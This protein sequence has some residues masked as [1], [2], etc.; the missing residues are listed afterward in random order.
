M[1]PFVFK[2]GKLKVFVD[3]AYQALGMG[4]DDAN[5]L[6]D[7]LVQ[8]EL[9]GHRS[10][11]VMRTFWYAERIQS[12]AITLNMAP[13]FVT[14]T[15]PIAVLDGKDGI[16]QAIARLAM[17]DAIERARK[18]GVG[19]VSVRNSGHFGTAMYF[20]RM[21][22]AAGCI[23]ILTT[24]ASPAMAPWGG[25]EKRIGN[26]PWSI[27][28]PTGGDCPMVLDIA[29][30]VVARGKIYHARERG[31][32]IPDGWAI[33]IDGVPT[34]DPA[35]A[36]AGNILPMGGHKGYVIST[37][38]E[39]LSGILSGSKFAPDVIGPYMPEG[40]SG[41]GHLAVVLNIEAFRPIAEFHADM[42]RLIATIKETPKAKGVEEV[43]FPGE[44]EARSEENLRDNGIAVPADTVAKLDTGARALGVPLLS[45]STDAP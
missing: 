18:F 15:G 14:D 30:T 5:L 22:A 16:G 21:A 44:V 12:G 45:A 13:E 39:V 36:I 17:S 37:M 19:V 38:M 33:D 10:H 42:Q 1:Q 24:N 2:V 3:T 7:T 28:A 40:A 4:I 6:A 11:G 31:E 34:N 43:F 26:N 23:G 41:V 8:A 9:W 20:T 25:K 32:S 35:L 29:N 27:A